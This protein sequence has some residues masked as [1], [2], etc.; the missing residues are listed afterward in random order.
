LIGR[1]VNRA[2]QL[3]AVSIIAATL[4]TA[5]FVTHPASALAAP[6]APAATHLVLLQSQGT[7]TQAVTA[8][9]NVGEFLKE[10]GIVPGTHDY[11]HPA[12]DTP[13][14]DNLIIEYTPAVPVHL[15]TPAGKEQILTSAPDVGALLEEQS[16][17][18]RAH[19]VVHPAL[20]VPIVANERIRVAS[21]MKWIVK[22]KHHVAQRTIHEIDFSLAPHQTRVVKKGTPGETLVTFAYTQTDGKIRKRVV[23]RKTL[24]KPQPR[25]I[26]EGVGT[27]DAI[28]QFA[29][30]GLEKMTYIASGALDM[31]ATAY[32]AECGGCS[33]YTSSGYHAGHGIVAVD[34][35]IIPLGTKLFIPGYGFAIAGDTGGAIVGNRID[36]G[37]DSVADAMQFGRRVIK[38]YTLH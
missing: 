19:D 28:A 33:G 20:D 24:R 18:L 29:H 14:S 6:D 31:V 30:R 12:I 25:I 8:A 16:I 36:L 11:V 15:I 37:F 13:L 17:Q 32:T 38:V 4:V 7:Q 22:E 34:P 27:Q 35:H 26:A 1:S 23:A 10:R 5:G 2:G 21:F 9:Q 3:L